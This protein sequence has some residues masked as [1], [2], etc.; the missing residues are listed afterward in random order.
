M[1]W[2]KCIVFLFIDMF[3]TIL[4][5]LKHKLNGLIW[6]IIKFTQRNEHITL[7]L[8]SKLFQL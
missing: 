5:E 8:N 3:D 1:F 4:E 7:K 2:G 6:P